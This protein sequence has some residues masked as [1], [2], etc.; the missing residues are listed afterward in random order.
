M[1]KLFILMYFAILPL[2]NVFAAE[3]DYIT[4]GIQL[5]K[6]FCRDEGTAYLTCY[7]SR[8]WPDMGCGKFSFK[9]IAKKDTP[10]AEQEVGKIGIA[11]SERSSRACQHDK[12]V[13]IGSLEIE[14]RFRENGYG[15]AAVRT[16]LGIFRAKSREKL[17]FDRFWLTVG[18]YEDRKAARALYEKVG[19]EVEAV[20]D[21][22]GYQY[23]TL[24]R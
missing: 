13:E 20:L 17:K 14:P 22:I 3:I 11:Y 4:P 1:K 19:F 2:M 15:E 5:G 16:V 12:T 18:L 8:E 24:K 9:I 7:D 21:H 10:F 6:K 23:M